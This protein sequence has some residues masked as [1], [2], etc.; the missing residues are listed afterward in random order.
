MKLHTSSAMRYNRIH[1]I[2]IYF[3]SLFVISFIYN[4]YR[5]I[6]HPQRVINM[7]IIVVFKKFN[8]LNFSRNKFHNENWQFSHVDKKQFH[9]LTISHIKNKTSSI[10]K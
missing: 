1:W 8:N 4:I 3:V 5:K 10:S 6:C 2:N 7:Y 9:W